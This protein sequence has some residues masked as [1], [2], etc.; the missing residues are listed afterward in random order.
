[1]P[2]GYTH[3]T[4]VTTLTT[5]VDEKDNN[6][7]GRLVIGSAYCLVT[8]KTLLRPQFAG[9]SE[10]MAERSQGTDD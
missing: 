4:I 3:E 7:G 2:I 6:V 8:R 9:S 1:M 10:K 5:A